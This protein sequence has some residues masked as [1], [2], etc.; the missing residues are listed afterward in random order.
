MPSA[1]CWLLPSRVQGS[2]RGPVELSRSILCR[3]ALHLLKE[4]ASEFLRRCSI[5]CLEDAMLHPQLPVVVWLMCAVAKGYRLGVALAECCLT[6]VAQ[7]ASVPVQDSLAL[8]QGDLAGQPEGEDSDEEAEMG[9]MLTRPASQTQ[10]MQQDAGVS[11]QAHGTNMEALQ[12][13]DAPAATTNGSVPV[14]SP[15]AAAA[16]SGSQGAACSSGNN[17]QQQLTPQQTVLIRSMRIRAAFGGM[18]GDLRMLHGFAELWTRRQALLPTACEASGHAADALEVVQGL[19]TLTS[20][21]LSLPACQLGVLQALHS[22]GR[23]PET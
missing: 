16:G 14:G 3:V 9:R 2:L 11:R 1:E 15:A 10:S 21:P 12:S 22:M 8:P 23:L 19:S 5:I 4:D 7:M 20:A 17:L 6:L 18:K 13:V